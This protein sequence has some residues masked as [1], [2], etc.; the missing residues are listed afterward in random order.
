M[1]E[2][3]IKVEETK[4]KVDV[5]DDGVLDNMTTKITS[6]DVNADGKVDYVQTDVVVTDNIGNVLQSKIEIA[7]DE[8]GVGGVASLSLIP[9][10]EG[11]KALL[12]EISSLQAKVSCEKLQHLGSMQDYSELFKKAQEYMEEV[13]DKNINLIID[14]AVLDKFAAEAAIYSQMFSEVNLQF[15]RLSTVND[16]ETLTKIRDSLIKINLMYENIAKFHASITATSILQIPESIKVVSEYLQ[17]VNESIQCSLPYLEYFADNSVELS[18]D[19][20]ARAEL[21]GEDRAAI[22]A[23][24]NALNVWIDMVRNEA[25]VTMNG[26]AYIKAFKDKIASFDPLYDRLHAVVSKVAARLAKWKLG[27]YA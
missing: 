17:T 8:V 16:I 18:E 23:A 6:T 9:A 21:N 2:P 20:K 24:I 5:N 25:N 1:T 7:S 15:N 11:S 26:N 22:N 4:T 19:Q 12:S 10:S 3:I 13:G 27:N 14:T